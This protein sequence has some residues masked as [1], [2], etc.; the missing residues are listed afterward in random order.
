M[1][2]LGLLDKAFLLTESRQTPMHVGGL[3]LFN[4]PRQ[5]NEQE[6][7]HELAAGLSNAQE[8]QHPF[9]GKLKTSLLGLAGPAYWETDTA[10]DM[11]Y[12]IRHSA[13]PAPGRYRE[14]FTLVS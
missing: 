7:L 14:L 13:L 9:G 2:K 1:K 8:L 3:S 10:L 12:H 4:L 11:G 5:A 6:F